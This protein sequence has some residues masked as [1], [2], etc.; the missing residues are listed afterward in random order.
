MSTAERH[1]PRREQLAYGL[2]DFA[3]VLYWQTFMVYL[4]YFYTDVFG[5]GAAAVGTMLGLSR[6]LDAVFDPV[7]GLLA[8]RTSTRWGKFR[9]YL[10]WLCVPFAVAGVL[11]FS[12]PS[13]GTDGKLVWAWVTYNLL[14]VLYTGINIP[15]TAMLG[16]LTP[17]AQE[18]TALAS[19]KFV[20][21]FAAGTLLSATLLPMARGL[22]GGDTARG[23]QLCFVV[24]GALAVACF[25]TTFWS[26]R[27]RVQPPREQRSSVGRDLRDLLSNGPWLVLLFATLTLILFVAVR[28][29]VTVH[30][31]KYF[32]GSR[33]LSLPRFLPA[34]GGEQTWHFEGLVSAFNTMGQLASLLGVL[35]LPLVTRRLG[36]KRSFVALFAAAI[37]A[38]AGYYWVR[39]DQLGWIF[40]LNLVI[41]L[42]GGPLSAVLWA[43]YADTADYAEW[44]N[45]R[46]AT[47][48]VFSASA[49]AQ[50]QGWALGAW[51]ALSLMQNLG[52]A[53]NLDQTPQSLHGLVLLMS[54][55]PAALGVLSVLCSLAY[56]LDE[57]RL[58]VIGQELAQR[59]AQEPGA[60]TA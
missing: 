57:S 42:C 22:G 41:S 8:D 47:G 50:K 19:V 55:V 17:S 16:V 53:A 48:L 7:M 34:I 29:S 30:Y 31:F 45:G 25:L 2:G 3:S 46:R 52:F 60:R 13:L 12:V 35:L 54:L 28:S 49:F 1:L 51:L 36:R 24:I 10:L 15:Y 33:T 14:M 43:M 26:T 27:E 21:A 9:P 4:T 6:S 40:V 5:L 23:W 39:A 18:R 58:R 56:P 59:R 11:T 37:A 20:F 38:T 32:V 44:K